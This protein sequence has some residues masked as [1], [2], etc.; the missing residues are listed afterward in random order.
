[1][2]QVN[3][4]KPHRGLVQNVTFVPKEHVDRSD[5]V[6][7]GG[8]NDYDEGLM[9]LQFSKP[10]YIKGVVDA[11]ENPKYGTKGSKA[12]VFNINRAHSKLVMAEFRIEV[13]RSD[14]WTAKATTSTVKD[15]VRR[16]WSGSRKRRA[17]SC[18]T[19]IS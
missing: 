14:T 11:Y 7:D 1:L 6:A 17:R 15:T 9:A 12:I 18:V 8:G 16:R 3:K 4:A 5:L 10:Q 2:I 13:T 19:S